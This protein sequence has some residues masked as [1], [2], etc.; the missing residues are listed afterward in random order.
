VDDV[1]LRL[2]DQGADAERADAVIDE[3]VLGL[4]DA[5][6]ASDAATGEALGRQRLPL[7]Q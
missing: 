1:A 7:A 3:P 5:A 4:V 2:D 6:A